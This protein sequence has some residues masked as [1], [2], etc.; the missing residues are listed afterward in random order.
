MLYTVLW[1]LE[2]LPHGNNNDRVSRE[3]QGA[4]FTCPLVKLVM[5]DVEVF[6]NS[7]SMGNVW[8]LE[9]SKTKYG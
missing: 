3:A 9:S 5:Y 4:C 7:M 6:G 1:Y 8:W 2:E